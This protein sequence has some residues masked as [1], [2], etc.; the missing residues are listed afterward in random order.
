MN[1]YVHDNTVV[2]SAGSDIAVFWGDYGNRRV[3]DVASNNRGAND[4]YWY[5]MA[6]DGQTR[7]TWGSTGFS[8]LSAFANV[9]AEQSGG[10]I[11]TA[12]RDQLLSASGV[13]LAP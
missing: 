10:Y 8:S 1:A 4:R 9:P 12:Q 13:P 7:F 6:E 2:E 11:S 3:F 5:P